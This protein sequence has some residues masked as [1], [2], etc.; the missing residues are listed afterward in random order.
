M[1]FKRYMVFVCETHEP[2]GGLL[3]VKESFDTLGEARAFSESE[4][5]RVREYAWVEIF[6]RVDGYLICHACDVS[7]ADGFSGRCRACT[8]EKQAGCS[9]TNWSR[10]LDACLDCGIGRDD[11]P[12]VVLK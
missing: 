4:R 8:L 9:H 2:G 3:D 5:V 11:L 1:T 7:P 12:R 6:D 10:N